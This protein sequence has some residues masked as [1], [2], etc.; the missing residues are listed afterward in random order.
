MLTIDQIIVNMAFKIKNTT[1]I[2]VLKD[3]FY[4]KFGVKI[5]DF[6]PQIVVGQIIG[7]LFWDEGKTIVFNEVV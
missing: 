1:E 4:K 7:R 5:F 6:K 2:A 3:I